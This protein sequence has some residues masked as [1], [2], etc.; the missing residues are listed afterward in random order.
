MLLQQ[1]GCYQFRHPLDDVLSSEK[2][3]VGLRARIK[4]ALTKRTAVRGKSGWMVNGSL[5]EGEQ[6]VRQFSDLMLR[7]Y[8]IEADNCVRTVRAHTLDTVAKRPPSR[9]ATPRA[10]LRA[11]RRHLTGVRPVTSGTSAH[12][13]CRHARPGGWGG[14]GSSFVLLSGAALS[15]PKLAGPDGLLETHVPHARCRM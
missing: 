4:E 6:L 11:H 13:S 8:N 15:G 2:R 12:T 5:K 14:N 9:S 10:L 3:L 1:V 7:T